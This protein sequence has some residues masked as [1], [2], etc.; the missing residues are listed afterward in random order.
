MALAQITFADSPGL[1][2]AIYAKDWN[3][4]HVDGQWMAD[5][6]ADV[7]AY[8]NAW[9]G[10]ADQL[11]YLKAQKLDAL[12]TQLA[13]I[14]AAGRLV[15]VQGVQKNYQIDDASRA[16]IAAAGSLAATILA[17]TPNA[18]PWNPSFYWIAAD[19]SRQPMTESDCYA[20]AQNVASY[21]TA[22]VCTNRALK[23]A[24]NNAADAATVS[25]IDVTKGW[26]SNP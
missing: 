12:S 10:S 19:N 5:P 21:Y 15:T 22:I 3:F 14:I 7:Q 20:F 13:S 23:D 25:A 8:V 17:R 26:P 11:A 9:N 24:I 18:D 16:N 4:A 1:I 2:E 6:A